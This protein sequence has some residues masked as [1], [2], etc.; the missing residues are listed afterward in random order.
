MLI[1]SYFSALGCFS[2]A[3]HS[4][5]R[6][7]A[8]K[9]EKNKST[10]THKFCSRGKILMLDCKIAFGSICSRQIGANADSIVSG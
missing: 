7:L 6:S 8:N 5:A 3:C 4:I 1:I 10:L 2:A 9:D